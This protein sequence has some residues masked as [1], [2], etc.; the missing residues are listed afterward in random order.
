MKSFDEIVKEIK[1][2]RQ[3]IF[4]MSPRQLLQMFNSYKRTPGNIAYINN[5]L[6]SHNLITEPDYTTIWFDDKIIL[7]HKDTAKT[8]LDGNSILTIGILP[9][10]NKPPIVINRDAKI[11]EAITLMML[12]KYSQLPVVGNKTVEGIISWESIGRN[13]MNGIQS[14]GVK[15]FLNKNI[16]VLSKDT[17]LLDSI[18]IVLENELVL[19]ENKDKSLSGI[20]TLADISS[21]FFI[22]TEP[23][24]LLEQIEKSIRL[25]LSEKILQEDLKKCCKDG[26]R[27]PKYIDDLTFGQYIRLIENPEI[28]R[29]LDL[30]MDRA[31]L[32]NKLEDIRSVRNDIMHF[33]PE[34]ITD[35]QMQSLK[36]MTSLVTELVKIQNLRK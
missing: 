31:I 24:L 14:D 6:Q 11:S 36:D 27:E 18:K 13:M 9:S 16:K 1:S 12:H 21:Q 10:A 17:P 23:F 7:R 20:I 28:W 4:K 3:K 33:N 25:L 19:V 15:D 5:E 8:K 32:R 26:E 29:K 30:K 22:S 2:D 35:E 34:G